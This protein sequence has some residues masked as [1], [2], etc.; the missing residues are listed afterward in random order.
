MALEQA[1]GEKDIDHRADIWSLGVILYECLSGSRP[2]EGE[3]LPQVVAR[4]MSAGIT[5]LECIA[6]G[7]PGEVTALVT[8]MLTRELARRTSNLL[9]VS[10][11]LGRHTRIKAPAFG[12]PG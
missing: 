2:I 4:L 8:Q 1:Y 11:V 3:S 5:P 7:L 10:E 12:V 6:P 9:E